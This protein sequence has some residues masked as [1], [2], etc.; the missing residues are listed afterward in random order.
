VWLAPDASV[1]ALTASLR[2]A[3]RTLRP[4]ERFAH[5][6]VE[7]FRIERAIGAYEKLIDRMLEGNTDA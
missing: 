2:T 3:L 4:G 7:V 1:E 6:F 5:P